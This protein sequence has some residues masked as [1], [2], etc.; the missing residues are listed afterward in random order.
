MS[1]CESHKCHGLGY[2]L[3]NCCRLCR[4]VNCEIVLSL[5]PT[6][7]ANA[8][9]SA[10]KPPKQDLYPLDVYFCHDCT[11][12]QLFNVVDPDI[13]FR[14]YV[15]V[16]GTSQV[17]RTH[18]EQ[19][20]Q[21]VLEYSLASPGDLVAEFGSNDGTL[22]NYF[23]KLGF[24][25]IGVD[26]AVNLAA[27]A[28][29][30]GIPTVPEFFNVDTARKIV[31]DHGKAKVICA[32]HCCAH[33]DDFLGIVE[34]VKELL[35]EDGVWIFEVGYFLDVF[36][37]NLFDTIYHEHL[38]FHTIRPLVSCLANHGMELLH[39][40]RSS[41]Q[42]GAIRCFVGWKDA[43]KMFKKLLEC[44]TDT[45][46]QLLLE[47]SAAFLHNPQVL[48]DWNSRIQ[49]IGSELRSL[50]NG[51]K[52]II[53]GF[54]APAKATTLMYTFGLSR[55]HINYIVDDNELKQGLL[56]PGLHI[57][58]EKPFKIYEDMPKY[59]IILA[60]NFADSI[61]AQHSA[62]LKAGGCFIVPLPTLRVVKCE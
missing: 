9:V 38:D 7:P 1:I 49:Q 15:Y 27:V 40:T 54:G 19:Y 12:V 8:F 30:N 62:Y 36:Q 10:V 4:S 3:R 52:G 42:G 11:H 26:P 43:V 22:L 58:V 61:I 23:K 6:P 48:R 16:S 32:N 28:T 60:W 31:L 56:T 57:P 20:A 37:N 13:L 34:G 41:I 53:I 46:R 50:L 17:M 14:N 2:S 45:V 25:I 39:V 44:S 55:Q 24:R 18:L 29:Q 47:E 33:I 5:A 35:K 21:E 51:L 59:I